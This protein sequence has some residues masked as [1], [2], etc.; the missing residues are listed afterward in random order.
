MTNI[1]SINFYLKNKHKMRSMLSHKR[2]KLL[3]FLS[4]QASTT[5]YNN[6]Y[7]YFFNLYLFRIINK[8]DRSFDVNTKSLEMGSLVS[9]H[10]I[11]AYNNLHKNPLQLLRTPLNRRPIENVN[12]LQ[13]IQFFYFNEFLNIKNKT[14]FKSK[15]NEK[16]PDNFAINYQKTKFNYYYDTS[17]L[18]FTW[19]D[20]F[21]PGLFNFSPTRFWFLFVHSPA[22][23]KYKSNWLISSLDEFYLIFFFS[24]IFTL[25]LQKTIPAFLIMDL[26]YIVY[27]FTND[28]KLTEERDE[29]YI[30]SLEGIFDGLLFFSSVS[31][32]SRANLLF[33]QASWLDCLHDEL[34]KETSKWVMPVKEEIDIHDLIE[35]QQF[36]ELDDWWEGIFYVFL[37]DSYIWPFVDYSETDFILAW[38]NYILEQNFESMNFFFI[39]YSFLYLQNKPHSFFN[40]IGID[41]VNKV[42]TDFINGNF[43]YTKREKHSFHIL[44][45]VL[46]TLNAWVLSGYAGRDRR[47]L[48]YRFIYLF[49]LKLRGIFFYWYMFLLKPVIFNLPWHVEIKHIETIF[50]TNQMYYA[51][52]ASIEL[53]NEF[54][55]HF[56]FLE[57]PFSFVYF[58]AF[59][60]KYIWARLVNQKRNQLEPDFMVNFERLILRKPYWAY[61][62]SKRITKRVYIAL[63]WDFFYYKYYYWYLIVKCF[64]SWWEVWKNE[65][66]Y[67]KKII[68][69]FFEEEQKLFKLSQRKGA[70]YSYIK[71]NAQPVKLK[72]KKIKIEYSLT[73]LNVIFSLL[74]YV[75]RM[76]TY[77]FTS[78][79][80]LPRFTYSLLFQRALYHILQSILL[81]FK[82]MLNL[83]FSLFYEIVIDYNIGRLARLALKNKSEMWFKSTEPE[84]LVSGVRQHVLS[85][86]LNKK[87]TVYSKSL[88]IT[89]TLFTAKLDRVN[90]FFLLRLCF[91]YYPLKWVYNFIVFFF[92]FFST[93]VNFYLI[94]YVFIAHLVIELKSAIKTYHDSNFELQAETFKKKEKWKVRINVKSKKQLAVVINFDVHSVFFLYKISKHLKQARE[95]YFK[96]NIYLK[97]SPQIFPFLLVGDTKPNNYILYISLFTS[98]SQ[99]LTAVLVLI[100]FNIHWF[101]WVFRNQWNKW[102]FFNFIFNFILYSLISFGFFLSLIFFFVGKSFFLNRSFCFFL[103]WLY[104]IYFLFYKSLLSFLFFIFNIQIYFFYTL[105]YE[106]KRKYL[107]FFKAQL[108]LQKMNKV[109]SHAKLIVISTLS[110]LMSV[111]L[112]NEKSMKTTEQFVHSIVLCDFMIL[113]LYLYLIYSLN[114]IWRKLNKVLYQFWLIFLLLLI[115]LI[116]IGYML[117]DCYLSFNAV[118]YKKNSHEFLYL[119][120]I[121]SFIRFEFRDSWVVVKELIF[122]GSLA[123]RFMLMCFGFFIYTVYQIGWRF[124]KSFS[125]K[126]G[127]TNL[128]TI[129]TTYQVLRFLDKWVL[130]FFYRVRQ[131]YFFNFKSTFFFIFYNGLAYIIYFTGK[132]IFYL[133]YLFIFCKHFIQL[134]APTFFN[135]MLKWYEMYLNIKIKIKFFNFILYY[136]YIN[137]SA[138]FMLF[139]KNI[140]VN[141]II[142]RSYP[143]KINFL[144]S[145]LLSTIY[146]ISRLIS[147][148]YNR[149]ISSYQWST[150]D[151]KKRAVF[152]INTDIRDFQELLVFINK[153][154]N[155]IT[156][157]WSMVLQISI[158]YG[159]FGWWLPYSSKIL[160][161]SITETVNKWRVFSIQSFKSNKFENKR[162]WKTLDEQRFHKKHSYYFS[163]NKITKP[164]LRQK[165]FLNDNIFH[166]SFTPNRKKFKWFQRFFFFISKLYSLLGVSFF[167]EIMY[168]RFKTPISQFFFSYE[169]SYNKSNNLFLLLR[170]NKIKDTLGHL[171]WH[172]WHLRDTT[173]TFV[174]DDFG[175]N[176]WK[177]IT[178]KYITKN[179]YFNKANSSLFYPL[180][181][182]KNQTI[183]KLFAIK[184]NTNI[185]VIYNFIKYII[186][187]IFILFFIWCA[188]FIFFL[189][190]SLFII[191]CCWRFFYFF[192]TFLNFY[193]NVKMCLYFSI[194][195]TFFHFFFLM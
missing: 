15:V 76:Q 31:L 6:F 167:F 90:W 46:L 69:F 133:N 183:S 26:K 159:D 113:D 176:L 61:I 70:L 165:A 190:S 174:L 52:R 10:H 160:Q 179:Q 136:Y 85:N 24:R 152:N 11:V 137:W 68:L 161:N 194:I 132:F 182:S 92:W 122:I 181:R 166:S 135:L 123:L 173:K 23:V 54:K 151:L 138:T 128:W 91:Y 4:F 110:I 146:L 145:V 124:K 169:S 170:L 58:W 172:L 108:Y 125:K 59:F 93:L 62:Y 63:F 148:L 134:E 81:V 164:L 84:F 101:L 42:W 45:K 80:Y 74:L 100:G 41:L 175:L 17:L 117:Y 116:C 67:S 19:A 50:A 142:N 127:K 64:L 95:E 143:K 36:Y 30:K 105:I 103:L 153:N 9:R 149:S 99:F 119:R 121:L 20:F 18:Y 158:D 168:Q 79:W 78:Y 56:A 66:K 40:K 34:F 118:W 5:F 77:E 94:V 89:Y 187:F 28:L 12:Y 22:F 2:K 21:S 126:E 115:M 35:E 162:L 75:K 71:F 106:K 37:A 53:T 1:S 186:S 193:I 140:H 178:N 154:Y 120:A 14:P 25:R 192:C 156:F 87:Q 60:S 3:N 177:Y 147:W 129:P 144:M 141:Y 195:Y 51:K 171:K 109:F 180:T 13:N 150:Q 65:K 88:T 102:Y 189:F 107:L 73:K 82:S 96:A 55:R 97:E 44:G 8:Y 39:D 112:T 130:Y 98:C 47:V 72:K 43:L 38:K 114:I 27:E 185:S 33:F 7:N 29:L 16:E 104:K 191:S 57:K 163:L 111:G 155:F 131:I 49:L 188:F 48:F 139:I 157:Y 32:K 86:S 184:T 83:F